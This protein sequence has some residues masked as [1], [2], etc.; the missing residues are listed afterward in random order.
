MWILIAIIGTT[1]VRVLVKDKAACELTGARTNAD[2]VVC[3]D[4]MG[5]TR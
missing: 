1:Q 3:V 4:A 5:R 2:K